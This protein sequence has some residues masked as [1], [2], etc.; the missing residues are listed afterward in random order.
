MYT[1]SHSSAGMISTQFQP[2]VLGIILAF[3]SHFLLDN[4]QENYPFDDHRIIAVELNLNSYLM[5]DAKSQDNW[6]WLFGGML[7]AN[8]PDI[9]QILNPDNE[10]LKHDV[11]W[12]PIRLSIE[13]TIIFNIA[14]TALAS[15]YINS[16]NKKREI[17]EDP[18]EKYKVEGSLFDTYNEYFRSNSYFGFSLYNLDTL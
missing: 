8:L 15:W 2:N 3:T 11:Q 17:Y 7:A 1:S 13:E 4:L 18:L 14:M 6:D 12:F 9:L 10:F 5:S 16:D